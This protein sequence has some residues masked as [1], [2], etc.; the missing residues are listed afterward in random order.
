MRAKGAEKI[1]SQG[2]IVAGPSSTNDPR[3]STAAAVAGGSRTVTVYGPR[4]RKND[5][6]DEGIAK[7]KV[8]LNTSEANRL[9][10]TFHNL[11]LKSKKNK[12]SKG[13]NR[14]RNMREDKAEGEATVI[15]SEMDEEMQD[16]K[17]NDEACDMDVDA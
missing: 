2:K 10:V 14:N 16:A 17:H 6:E 11:D 9:V 15:A 12:K 5:G 13:R 1:T 7:V 3:Q 8:T 4:R